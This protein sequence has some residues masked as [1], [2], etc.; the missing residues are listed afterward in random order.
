MTIVL[1]LLKASLLLA[2]ALL[3]T[4]LLRTAPAATRHGLWSVTFVALL[5]LPALD[6]TI[7]AVQVPVPRAWTAMVPGSLSG[8]TPVLKAAPGP[9]DARPALSSGNV[10]AAHETVATSVPASWSAPAFRTPSLGTAA[11]LVWL[12]G[13]LA[14][15]G[16]LL[17]SL[18]RVRHLARTAADVT[19]PAWREAADTIGARLGI[20]GPARVLI[21]GAVR[22]P[23]AGGVWR[24]MIFL[25][26]DAASWSGER[27]DIVLA[28][29]LSHI[30]RRDPLRHLAARVAVGCYWFHPLA[31][32]AAKHASLAREQACDENVLALGIR[33]S[34]YARV[35]LD[36]A[37]TMAR[38]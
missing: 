27:R 26:P 32:I 6:G 2:A 24:P 28:H 21:S 10:R 36:L 37:D 19:D 38:P 7:P 22:T 15:A 5:A 23:M 1:I 14:A 11:R 34:D 35:L 31:W 29:E 18:V 17:L 16:V 8:P 20:R 12:A 30:A 33:P 3:G 13:A 25:P 4:R 9:E